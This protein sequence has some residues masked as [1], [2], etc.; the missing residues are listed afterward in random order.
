[1]LWRREGKGRFS[2][3]APRWHV[4]AHGWDFL[5]HKHFL[6]RRLSLPFRSLV[7]FKQRPIITLS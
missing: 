1:M 2:E 4:T 7:A 3:I 6:C 5:P